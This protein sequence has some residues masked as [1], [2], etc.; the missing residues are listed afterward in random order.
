MTPR[1]YSR[2]D[3]ALTC[4]ERVVKRVALTLIALLIVVELFSLSVE[5]GY[6]QRDAELS[7]Q[8]VGAI[9]VRVLMERSNKH[10]H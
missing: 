7:A 4:A 5:F 6:E 8:L 3:R 9:P 1:M 2:C 10:G